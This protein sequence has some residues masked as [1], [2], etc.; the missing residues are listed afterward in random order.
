MHGLAAAHIRLLSF[1][2]RQTPYITGIWA[3]ADTRLCF[4]QTVAW[5]ILPSL[6]LPRT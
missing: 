2:Y 5:T 1:R 3:P 6:A 4:S